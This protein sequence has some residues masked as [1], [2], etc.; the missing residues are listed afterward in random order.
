MNWTEKEK[1]AGASSRLS[2]RRFLCAVTT[3][4]QVDLSQHEGEP[5]I[6]CQ[7]RIQCW[8]EDSL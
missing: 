5:G 2:E 3:T 6:L 8:A 4:A 1:F 7:S